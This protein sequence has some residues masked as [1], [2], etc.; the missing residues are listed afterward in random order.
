MLQ[1]PSYS[2]ATGP[3]IDEPD[4]LR[5]VAIKDVVHGVN[6]KPA[7]L[8]YGHGVVMD[9]LMEAPLKKKPQP[10]CRWDASSN[11]RDQHEFS[12]ALA[13]QLAA[14]FLYASR[15]TNGESRECVPK[16]IHKWG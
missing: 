15:G 16:G 1:F 9:H 11:E 12:A 10:G 8:D 13:G 14:D 3:S 2:A 6:V 7:I 5:T 4:V